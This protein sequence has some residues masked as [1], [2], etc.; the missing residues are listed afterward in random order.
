MQIGAASMPILASLKYHS[1]TLLIHRERGIPLPSH[2]GPRDRLGPFI[3]AGRHAV[4]SGHQRLGGRAKETAEYH[5]LVSENISALD[6]RNRRSL[7]E[8]G[9]DIRHPV[10]G[11]GRDADQHR[12]LPQTP[13]RSHRADLL[14]AHPEAPTLTCYPNVHII[15]LGGG[16]SLDGIM[17][18]YEASEILRRPRPTRRVGSIRCVPRAIT[19]DR[20]GVVCASARSVDSR[21]CPPMAFRVRHRLST[22]DDRSFAVQ[23]CALPCR[24]LAGA[25]T[26]IS[27]RLRADVDRYLYRKLNSP[28]RLR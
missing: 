25:L 11:R 22:R 9:R 5:K 13:R 18:A 7:S 1:A 26:D 2:F 28:A 19:Q 17:A 3:F 16:I 23:A 24:R 14:V 12:G 21:R 8:R 4:A 27:A 10:Q 6:C 20:K 15:V